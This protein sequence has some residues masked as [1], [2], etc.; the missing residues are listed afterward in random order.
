MRSCLV[1]RTRSKV[2]S[3]VSAARAEPMMPKTGRNPAVS[4][5]LR[6]LRR[7][8]SRL[9]V[10]RLLSLAR[11]RLIHTETSGRLPL[12]HPRGALRAPLMHPRRAL[13]APL[14]QLMGRD[15]ANPP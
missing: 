5:R 10:M 3:E 9:V 13:R 15:A 8:V 14:M 11:C 1:R 7:L 12:M 4:A 6:R 2:V